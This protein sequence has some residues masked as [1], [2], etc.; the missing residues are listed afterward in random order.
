[1]DRHGTTRWHHQLAPPGRQ[2]MTTRSARYGTGGIT[3]DKA[4]G[5]WVGT[6]ELPPHPDGR[7]NRRRVSHRD[8]D[9]MLAALEQLRGRVRDGEQIETGKGWTVKSWGEH[10]LAHVA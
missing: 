2:T 5:L 7:R 1:M 6:V 4:R 8:K 3:F 10:Y 9:Q